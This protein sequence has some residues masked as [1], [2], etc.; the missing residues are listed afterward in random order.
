MGDAIVIA[1]ALEPDR[2]GVV[3]APEGGPEDAP[4]EDRVEE[5]HLDESGPAVA[6]GAVV[7]PVVTA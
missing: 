6:V 5:V 7:V 4:E 3:P 2:V 1:I